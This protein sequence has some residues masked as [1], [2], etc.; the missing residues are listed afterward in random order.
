MTAAKPWHRDQASL[1]A[2]IAKLEATNI[3]VRKFV[4]TGLAYHAACGGE[5]LAL[6]ELQ[7]MCDAAVA[8]GEAGK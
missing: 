1:D 4:E 3:A 5:R 6:N 7:A 2:K 8:M